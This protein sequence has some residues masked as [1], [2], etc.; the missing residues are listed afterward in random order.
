M[1]RPDGRAIY[2]WKV[3]QLMV[4]GVAP[5]GP[6]GALAVEKP[7]L[8]FRAPYVEAYLAMYDVS[9]DGRFIIVAGETNRSRL[10]VALDAL[11]ANGGRR[12]SNR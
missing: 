6:G 1:W 9:R 11:G 12:R 3:D 5:K 10:V 8:L 4:A 2:Y 7:T